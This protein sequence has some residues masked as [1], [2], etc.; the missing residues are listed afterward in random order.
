MALTPIE[1]TGQARWGVFA[2]VSRDGQWDYREIAGSLWSVTHVPT[3]RRYWVTG[4]DQAREQTG[5]GTAAAFLAIG[6]PLPD[7]K[8]L[9]KGEHAAITLEL[10]TADMDR[11]LTQVQASEPDTVGL[12]TSRIR[13]RT[14]LGRRMLAGDMTRMLGVVYG[15]APTAWLDALRAVRPDLVPPH[16]AAQAAAC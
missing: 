11:M 1:I 7:G 3:G 2:A 13:P 4:L 16:I 5:D 14:E 6:K 10:S 15:H 12:A 8:P 9:A